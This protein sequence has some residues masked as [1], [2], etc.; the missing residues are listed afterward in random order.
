M[1][2]IA[3]GIAGFLTLAVTCYFTLFVT[4]YVLLRVD[5]LFSLFGVRIYTLRTFVVLAVTALVV[6]LS[7]AGAHKHRQAMDYS[8]TRVDLSSRI[9]GDV[10]KA[11]SRICCEILFAGPRLL[12]TAWDDLRTAWRLMNAD[13]AQIGTVLFYLYEKGAKASVQ[14]IQAALPGV[15]TMRVLPQLRDLPGIVWLVDKRG[16]VLLTQDLRDDL[17]A[18][19]GEEPNDS[20]IGHDGAEEPSPIGEDSEFQVQVRR[21]YET[22]GLPVYAPI[23]EV[24]RRYR[25]LAKIYHPDKSAEMEPEQ[26][27]H[28]E[29][30]MKRINEAYQKIIEHTHEEGV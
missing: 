10:L 26:R 18:A 20:Q 5:A 23:H 15:N 4:M 12:F 19:L 11:A 27:E 3:F 2:G 25:R 1:S 9:S 30:Q 28:C 16:V 13:G 17:R 21:W 7:F 24:K 6:L 22:L 14:E 8:D 29:E